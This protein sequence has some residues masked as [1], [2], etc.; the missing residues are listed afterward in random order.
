MF[1]LETN[2]ESGTVI[3]RMFTQQQTSYPLSSV[4]GNSVLYSQGL[5][6]GN[7]CTLAG[8]Y[9]ELLQGHGDN[10]GD[11]TIDQVYENDN[12]IFG[13]AG[14]QSPFTFTA[15]SSNVGRFTANS[16][17]NTTAYVYL[18]NNSEGVILDVNNSGTSCSDGYGSVDAGYIETQTA[19]TFTN[20]ALAGNYMLGQFPPFTSTATATVGETS[21]GSSGTYSSNASNGGQGDF[22]WDQATSGLTYGWSSQTY[23]TLSIENPGGTESS[24]AVISG[25]RMACIQ[26]TSNPPTIFLLQQ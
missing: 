21:I 18:Y 25:T 24:C 6:Y 2:S 7:G 20:A 26:N 11:Y 4:N 13:S 19:T 14:Q 10:S 17:T 3:G 1:L 12:G 5:A 22:N 15:D 16:G 23:G 8:Y 9:S